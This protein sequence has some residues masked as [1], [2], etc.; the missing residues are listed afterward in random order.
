MYIYIYIYI[1]ISFLPF[2]NTSV[3]LG[4]DTMLYFLSAIMSSNI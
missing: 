3:T 1:C 2:K 4:L